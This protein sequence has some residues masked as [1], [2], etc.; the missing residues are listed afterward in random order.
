MYKSCS[1]LRRI[2]LY[3]EYGYFKI[4]DKLFNVPIEHQNMFGKRVNKRCIN[5]GSKKWLFKSFILRDDTN[6]KIEICDVCVRTLYVKGVPDV[7]CPNGGY[8]DP[9][10]ADSKHP[11]GQYVRSKRHKQQLLKQLNLREAGDD[12][13][14]KLGKKMPY[15][16]DHEQ[17]KKFLRDN[18]GLK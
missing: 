12:I 18:M 2:Y 17:R 6:E 14:K 10:L 16:K 13:N 11:D 8:F 4:K 9:N 1:L 3:I 5:C 15:I 7:T